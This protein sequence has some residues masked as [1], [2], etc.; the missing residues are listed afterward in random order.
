MKNENTTTTN[1]VFQL[2]YF[3]THTSIPAYRSSEIK[4]C[5]HHSKHSLIKKKVRQKNY[6]FRNSSEMNQDIFFR[7]CGPRHICL[8]SSIKVGICRSDGIKTYSSLMCCCCC[9]AAGLHEDCRAVH[10]HTH[11]HAPSPMPS[12]LQLLH[13]DDPGW[14]AP[15]SMV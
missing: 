5:G 15:I 3:Y 8:S 4:R 12:P 13:G 11:T 9:T 6:C 2:I 14:W 1:P 7:K 10:T